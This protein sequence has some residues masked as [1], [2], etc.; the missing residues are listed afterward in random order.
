MLWS[1]ADYLSDEIER[2]AFEFH[3]GVLGG[4]TEQEPLDERV[5]GEV[6]GMVG[7]AVGQLYVAEYFPP[8]AKEQITALVEA[9]D[10]R[11]PRS[12]SKPTPG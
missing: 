11:L 6:N 5:L 1:F 7:D 12:G 9:I 4:V 10:R 2:T 8:E 3:G